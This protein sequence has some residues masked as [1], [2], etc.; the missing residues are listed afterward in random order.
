V[1]NGL[2][3][4][5]SV[6]DQITGVLRVGGFVQCGPGYDGQPKVINGASDLLLEIFGNSG[7]HARAAVGVSALPLNASVEVEF[8]FL[9]G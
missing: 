7:R 9:A 6:T 8:A 5:Y 3:A 1:L 4:A 2:A